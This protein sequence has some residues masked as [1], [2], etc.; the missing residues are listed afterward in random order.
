MQR[1][2]GRVAVVTG[3]GSGIGAAS[4]RRLAREGASVVVADLDAGRA[5]DVAKV[6]TA[7]GGRAIGVA[8]DVTVRSAVAAAADAAMQEFGRLDVMH[9]NAGIG[10]LMPIVMTDDEAL[11]RLLAVNV[12]GVFNGLAVAGQLFLGQ[13]HG[14]IV[15]T[16]SISGLWGSPGMAVYAATK[17]A[18]I[19]LTRSAAMEFA[20][21]VR[22]NAV[23]PGGVRTQFMTTMLGPGA[24]ALQ[25][26]M[27][28]KTHPLGRNAEADEIA[29]AVAFLGSD[30][31]SFMT[32]AIMTVDGGTTAGAVLDFS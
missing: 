19:A 17:G 2:E 4:A 8:T 1:Y 14:A 10:L 20:P 16:A 23:A 28:A 30:D 24:E 31:A 3:G 18:V 6:I 21:T 15:N 12:K 29:A 25:D 22:V 7:D 5:E 32:G 13:G 11:D 27:G 26:K 9:N